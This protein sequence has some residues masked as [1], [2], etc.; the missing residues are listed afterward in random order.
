[1][2][3]SIPTAIIPQNY[4]IRARSPDPFR[5]RIVCF[6][7]RL[8]FESPTPPPP[9]TSASFVYDG[10]GKQVKSIINGVTTV[11]IGAH[12]E[13]TGSQ[14]TKYYFAGSQRIAIPQGDN[15]Q[16]YT[17][18]QT[19]TLRY[20]PTD[21]PSTGSGRRLGSISLATNSRIVIP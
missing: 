16:T 10:D 4:E 2:I 21:H 14:V 9:F 12:Y 17:V 19:P 20:M 3:L 5:Y 15:V 1:M 7:L 8:R 18:P 11:Y 6:S 13:M